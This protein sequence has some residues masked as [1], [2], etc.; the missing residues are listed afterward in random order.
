MGG[1][2]FYPISVK[3]YSLEDIELVPNLAARA[4]GGTVVHPSVYQGVLG[5]DFR[6]ALFFY[7]L[8]LKSVYL[9]RYRA[10][11]KFGHQGL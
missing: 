2:A 6:G 8:S 11:S 7:L 4:W 1:F 3:V 5:G 9:R 10:I